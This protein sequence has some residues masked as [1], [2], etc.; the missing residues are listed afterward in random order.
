MA[1]LYLTEQGAKITRTQTRLIV[2]KDGKLLLQLPI[3]KLDR[4]IIFGR[5]AITI[6]VLELLL[7]EGIPTA[8]LSQTGRLKG[9]LEPMPSKNILLRIRQ[10][11]RVKDELF[12]TEI[13]KSIVSG[14]IRN[15]KRLLQRFSHNHPELNFNSELT[16]IDSHIE[17]LNKKNSL[18]GILGME[19]IATAIYFQ[20]FAKLFKEPIQFLERTRRPPKDIINSLLSLGYTL[21]TNEYFSLTAASG[22]DPYIGFYHGI[23]Y[24]RPSLALD[25][26]EEL[27]HPVIDMLTL[28]LIMRQMLKAEDFTGNEDEGFFLTADGRKTFFTQYERRMNNEFLHPKNKTP[29][30]IRKVMREQVY[31]MMRAVESKKPYEPFLIG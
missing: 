24:G 20:G 22:F 12:R 8:F 25:L 1:T 13:A 15:Q 17:A 14:K 29:T 11:E 21:L 4:L 7:K 9:F 16:Q 10:Y 27:R 31:S 2:E 19:G 6:P 3:I 28:E 30:T 5:V 26:V 23:G 18:T